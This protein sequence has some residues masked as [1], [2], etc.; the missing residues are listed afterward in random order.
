MSKTYSVSLL[1]SLLASGAAF[2]DD[3]AVDV[4][5][6]SGRSSI[7]ITE[8][9]F[10]FHSNADVDGGTMPGGNDHQTGETLAVSGVYAVSSRVNITASLSWDY[11]SENTFT[12]QGD[13]QTTNQNGIGESL[14]V[15]AVL[16]DN[17]GAGFKLIAAAGSTHN[18]GY[19]PVYYA[20]LGPQYRF[21][22]KLLLTSSFGVQHEAGFS[23]SA[24]AVANLVWKVTPSF[25]VV[26]SLGATRYRASEY[27]SGYT[28]STEELSATYH[29]DRDWS[30]SAS[31]THGAQTTQTSSYYVND[32]ADAHSYNYGIGLRH[33]F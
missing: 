25:S 13:S 3:A 1:L 21:D 15:S 16:I 33:F 7:A 31:L 10:N 19:D 20:S 28:Q 11:A 17:N 9:A 14:G 5:G 23:G 24:Y 6:P 22:D 18:E 30:V 8:N 12:W 4:V 32:L 26:P 2:A 29:I 27:W